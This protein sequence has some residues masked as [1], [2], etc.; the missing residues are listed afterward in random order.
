MVGDGVVV[1]VDDDVDVDVD[2]ETYVGHVGVGVERIRSRSFAGSVTPGL[3]S[4]TSRFIRLIHI[5][6]LWESRKEY[7]KT[8]LKLYSFDNLKFIQ[9]SDARW[10]RYQAYAW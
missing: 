2:V 3:D 9:N 5:N 1:Y 6:L 4:P 10:R 8:R 7:G